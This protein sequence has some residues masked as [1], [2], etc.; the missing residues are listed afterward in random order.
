MT[1][2]DPAPEPFSTETTASWREL[3]VARSVDPARV[4][5]EK[6]VQRF[7]DAALELLSGESGKDFTVQEVVKK[8]GQSLRSFYQYFAGKH[9]L[10]LALFEESVSSTTVRLRD[11]L[12]EIDDPLERLHRFT[13]D[14]YRLC[15]PTATAPKERMAATLG[16]A[17]FA[18]QLMTEHPKEAA[19]AFGPINALLVELLEATAASGAVRQDL[20]LRRVAGTVLQATMFS[21]FAVTIGGL[22]AGDDTAAE[23]EELWELLFGGLTAEGHSAVK[24]PAKAAAK[25]VAPAKRAPAARKATPKKATTTEKTAAKKAPAKKPTTARTTKRAAD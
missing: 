22:H 11:A 10:L 25:S 14:Y 3:A 21:S 13:V 24:A 23:A 8:S 16:M 19:R 5:A 15:R 7:L 20:D 4:R 17:E 18:Q 6:R 1:T 12:E 2:S 9:E